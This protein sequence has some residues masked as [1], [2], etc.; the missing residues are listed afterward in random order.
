MLSNSLGGNSHTRFII[1]IRD[2]VDS[3]DDTSST[4][5]FAADV[6][7]I[8]NKTSI[9]KCYTIESLLVELDLAYT[10]I[11][12]LTRENTELKRKLDLKPS[13]NGKMND[14]R[15]VNELCISNSDGKVNDQQSVKLEEKVTE[16]GVKKMIS[17]G[18]TLETIKSKKS[19]ESANEEDQRSVKSSTKPTNGK[20]NE[21]DKRR[22]KSKESDNEE[23][24]LVDLIKSK[25]TCNQLDKISVIYNKLSEDYESE[26]IIL[27]LLLEQSALNTEIEKLRYK[28][29]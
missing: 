1:N 8:E 19:K 18:G 2:E 27:Q 23:D 17:N 7:K 6:Q 28:R 15:S 11:K 3:F 12:V 14:Q 4:L 24:Q 26:Q 9:N 25:G 21:A 20:V 29:L 13:G 10:K 16:D 22:L 5:R